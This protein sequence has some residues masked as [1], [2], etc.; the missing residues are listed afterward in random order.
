[1]NPSGDLPEQWCTQLL[2]SQT[3]F[4]DPDVHSQ[5]QGAS[6]GEASMGTLLTASCTT[7]WLDW[8]HGE[9][10]L[11]PN[12]LLRTRSGLGATIGHANRRTLPDEPV[13][14][15]FSP[16]E[17]DRL[18]RQHKTNLWIPRESILSASIFNGPLSGRLAL[19]LNDGRRL[20]LLWLRADRASEPL[21]HALTSWGI[22]I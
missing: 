14:R 6:A 18:Q 5:S 10:W 1:M 15:E 21:R 17:I 8:I 4:Y 16:G 22:S 11:L 20:K 2:S 9:L 13:R 12:G 7:G 19:K 3:A